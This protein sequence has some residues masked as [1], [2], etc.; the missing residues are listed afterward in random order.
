MG[1]LER[2]VYLGERPDI[3]A[4][5][6]YSKMHTHRIF[7][8]WLGL[9]PGKLLRYKQFLKAIDLIHHT[10]WNLSRIT[11]ECGFYDQSHFIRVFEEF[12]QLT[13]GAYQ[14]NKGPIPGILSW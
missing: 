7:K 14:K 1:Q 9:T 6:G 8:D 2:D 12:A 10:D 11:Y 13:P 5:S 3:S 4:Y